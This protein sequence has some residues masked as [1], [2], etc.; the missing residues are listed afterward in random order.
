MNG[1]DQIVSMLYIKDI[2]TSNTYSFCN[3]KSVSKDI[4][5]TMDIIA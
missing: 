4:E 5:N 3:V 1:S 2:L